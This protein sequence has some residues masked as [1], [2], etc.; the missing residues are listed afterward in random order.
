MFY[1][2]KTIFLSIKQKLI[3]LHKFLELPYGLLSYIRGSLRSDNISDRL[4]S[5]SVILVKLKTP[6]KSI[7]GEILVLTFATQIAP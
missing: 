2:L 1:L 5:F 4:G 3:S 6:K 7:L